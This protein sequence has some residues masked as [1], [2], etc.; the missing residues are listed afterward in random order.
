MEG[1]PVHW[2]WSEHPPLWFHKKS[3]IHRYLKGT[4][5]LSDQQ[6]SAE[7]GDEWHH[8]CKM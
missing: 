5:A 7:S 6:M 2:C 3:L 1:K 8:H 4:L